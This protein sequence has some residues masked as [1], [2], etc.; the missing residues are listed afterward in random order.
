[1]NTHDSVI[2]SDTMTDKHDI[3]NETML[4]AEELSAGQYDT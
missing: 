3:T 2:T 4:T 1:M